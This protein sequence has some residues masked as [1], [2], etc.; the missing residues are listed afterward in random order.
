MEENENT[1]HA[2][3]SQNSEEEPARTAHAIIMINCIRL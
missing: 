1:L 3:N 2:L